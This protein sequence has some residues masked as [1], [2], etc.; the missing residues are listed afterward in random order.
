MAGLSRELELARL[1]SGRCA[2]PPPPGLEHFEIRAKARSVADDVLER[3][4]DVLSRIILASSETWPTS[5]EWSTILPKWLVLASAHERSPE[6]A[7][8]WWDRLRQGRVEDREVALGSQP[9]SIGEFVHW[10]LPE[11]REWWWWGGEMIGDNRLRI[12]LIVEELTPSHGALDWLLQAAGAEDI[13]DENLRDLRQRSGR[14][15]W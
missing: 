11:Q 12:C 13:I 4:K 5:E 7:K 15:N 10:F 6:E 2:D 8:A 3:V 1:E 14:V 9:W